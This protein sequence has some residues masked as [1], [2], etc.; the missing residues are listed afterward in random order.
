MRLGSFFAC[1]YWSVERWSADRTL[2]SFFSGDKIS[3]MHVFGWWKVVSSLILGSAMAPVPTNIDT[4][5]H[6]LRRQGLHSA[7]HGLTPALSP[8]STHYWH[9]SLV[10]ILLSTWSSKFTISIRETL[11][12]MVKVCSFPFVI[13]RTYLAVSQDNHFDSGVKTSAPVSYG[14]HQI[15]H[16]DRV[17]LT[18]PPRELLLHPLYGQVAGF[19]TRC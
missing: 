13:E 2:L 18:E 8:L 10:E 19:V 1:Q 12:W 14:G 11:I 3:S 5:P 16:L 9:P 4:N 6:Q 7:M 15:C 17:A